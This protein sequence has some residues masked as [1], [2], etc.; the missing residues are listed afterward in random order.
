MNRLYFKLLPILALLALG[1]STA[2]AE[3]GYDLWLRYRPLEKAAQSRYAGIGATVVSASHSQ[4]ANV[5]RD[6]LVRGLSGLLAKK[7]TAG[8]AISNGAVLFGTPEN[9][10][11]I[12]A[13]R[14]PLEKLGPEGYLI[15]A[16]VVK[17]RKVT[18]IAG[19]SDVGVL[20][21]AFRFLK[22][23][24]TRA[25]LDHLDIA[26]APK[27]KLRL[28]N[29]WDNLDATVERG[30]AGSSIFKWWELPAHVSPQMIDYARANASVGINGT[31]LINVNASSLILTPEWLAKVARLADSFRPYGIKVYLVARFSA[32][33]EIGG[34]KTA[35]PL[36]PDVRAWWKNKADEIY[37]SIPDFGG[38]LVKANSEGQPGP[39]DY[40]RGHADGAN[41][42]AEA[43]APHGGVVM[44]RAF[45]YSHEVPVDRV[46]QAYDEFKPLDGKFRDNVILQVKNGPLDFQPREPF[47]ALFGATPDTAMGMEVQITKEY[48]GF[49]THLVYLGPLWQEVLGT[50]TF[51]KGQGS[52][53]A[54]VVDGT[55]F[56]KK[57]TLMAGV[58]NIGS[59]R[60]WCGSIFDQANWYAFGRLAWDPEAQA[61]DIASDWLKM[62]FTD[63]AAFDAP[64]LAL[65][66]GSRETAV[67]YMTPLGLAHLMGTSGHYGPGPWVDSAGRADWN[68]VYYHRADAQGIGFDRSPS[69]SD[70]V[71]QY[72]AP[73]RDALAKVETTPENLLLWFH[74]VPWTQPMKS[75]RTL[76]DELVTR[77]GQGV[78]EVETMAANW[79]KLKPYVDAE[80]FDITADYLRLQHRDALLWRD[81]SVA[82]FSSLSHLSLP[83]GQKTPPHSLGYYEALE[84]PYAPGQGAP[85]RKIKPPP[86]EAP[87][88]H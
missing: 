18:V 50:D 38:F 76:W 33:I 71:S 72:A 19:N 28:L 35:D 21:G 24:Q 41:M 37:H 88:S 52:T 42:L 86:V 66:M 61:K 1:F 53:V 22:L 67:N 84:F 60:N 13:L 14:L 64:A 31:V 80:R 45:V 34:L 75:G 32:P 43:L 56:D 7:V 63:N 23:I 27:V 25:P 87:T 6:E 57:L 78:S 49:N 8:E 26:S 2:H 82:Y 55:L 62:T 17:G 29:H 4:T 47:S 30:Y 40:G 54:K 20:Y 81:A 12:A 85:G 59:D 46:K 58:S 83:A 16:A 70:A 10:R 74:H 79:A 68:P 36:D 3:D 9:S 44:W 15:R 11:S 48:L 39:Q 77:Y 51:V 69:G 73:I 65:M 5:T